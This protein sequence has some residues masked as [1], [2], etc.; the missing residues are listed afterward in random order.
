[1]KAIKIAKNGCKLGYEFI[2]SNNGSAFDRNW[3]S[4]PVV[5]IILNPSLHVQKDGASMA[6]RLTAYEN[7]IVF[8]GVAG[9]AR[10]AAAADK[11]ARAYIKANN[12]RNHESMI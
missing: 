8:R 4:S 11:M 1:M 3:E 7:S 9:K 2:G 5:V 12:L 10:T 6:E